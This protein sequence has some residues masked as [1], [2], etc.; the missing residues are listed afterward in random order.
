MME[1]HGPEK[2][3]ALFDAIKQ[4]RSVEDAVPQVYGLTLNQL[5]REWL[6]EEFT[7]ASLDRIQDPGQ[8]GTSALL[9]AAAAFTTVVMIIRW[10]RNIGTP[11]D[12][13]D[14]NR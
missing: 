3:A 12:A 4:G 11:A 6:G 2:M 9:A 5:E 10:I 7:G 13:E 8:V 14:T 1:V